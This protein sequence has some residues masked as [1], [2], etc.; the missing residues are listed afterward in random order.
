MPRHGSMLLIFIM[1][2]YSSGLHNTLFRF[3]EKTEIYIYL[4]M[5]RPQASMSA[6]MAEYDGC[7]ELK[8]KD[9]FSVFPPSVSSAR[10]EPRVGGMHVSKR[11]T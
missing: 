10:L 2:K 4:M 3:R 9:K 7:D 8:L 5:T 1:I 6:G 11:V